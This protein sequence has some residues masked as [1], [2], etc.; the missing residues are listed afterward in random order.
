MKTL[1]LFLLNAILLANNLFSQQ[2]NKNRSLIYNPFIS[3]G[4]LSSSPNLVSDYYHLIISTYHS[5]GVPMQTQTDFGR[6]FNVNGGVYFS[7]L[8]KVEVGIALGYMYSP[9]Y[10]NYLDV[11]G[12]LKVDGFIKSYK[13]SLVGESA[14]SKFGDFP[15]NILFEGGLSYS[16]ASIS[17]ILVLN[18]GNENN[19]DIENGQL[20]LG[21]LFSRAAIGTSI[22]FWRFFISSTGWLSSKFEFIFP[23]YK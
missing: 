19:F 11:N 13:I 2:Q 21:D 6:T 12:K 16:A 22:Q 10:S 18:A 15:L 7:L 1:I 8:K 20:M 5:E 23:G 9:A 3:V 17:R 14:I 4:Y